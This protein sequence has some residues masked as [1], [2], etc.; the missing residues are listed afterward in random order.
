MVPAADLLPVSVESI[1]VA[2]AII[3]CGYFVF[4]VSGFGS[5][6]LTV[7]VLSHLWPMTFVLPVLSLLDVIAAAYLGVRHHRQAER[8]ELTRMIPLAFIGALIGA[9][10]LVNLSRTTTQIGVGAL[11]LLYALYTLVERANPPLISRGWA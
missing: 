11:V 3:V 6:L 1:A 10:L 4:G 9:L 2:A 8:G 5:A 7:P